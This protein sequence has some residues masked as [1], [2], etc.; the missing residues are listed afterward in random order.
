MFLYAWDKFF[1]R[2]LCECAIKIRMIHCVLIIVNSS[3]PIWLGSVTN[4]AAEPMDPYPSR[5]G[6]GKGKRQGNGLKTKQQQRARG[7]N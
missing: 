1:R 5:G 3:G 4:G 2:R 7:E 6:R